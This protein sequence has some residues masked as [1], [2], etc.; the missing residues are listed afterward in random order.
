M[1]CPKEKEVIKTVDIIDVNISHE[2]IELTGKNGK[3]AE[4]VEYNK[5]AHAQELKQC[6]MYHKE[7]MNEH[8]RAI[9]KLYATFERM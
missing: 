1:G 2:G 3:I 7:R 8:T 9:K 6:I 4:V 5:I